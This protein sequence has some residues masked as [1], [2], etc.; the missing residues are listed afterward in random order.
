MSSDFVSK[1]GIR[2]LDADLQRLASNFSC[3][4]FHI[5]RF[6][7]SP[8]AL[9]SKYGKTYVWVTND[10]KGIIGF[11]NIEAG[12]VD[13][14]VDG[15]RSKMGGAIHINDFALDSRYQKIKIGEHSYISDLLLKDC[16]DRI[17]FIR[18]QFLGCTFITL[19]S[20]EA[21]R[22]LYLRNDFEQIEIDMDVTK[23]EEKETGCI[24]M[25]LPLD[26]E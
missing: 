9:D 15:E 11:Y 19:Q 6:I 21:G 4:N 3:G 16:I 20:N 24:A 25:Y 1:Y 22:K 26:I 8:L 7:K 18:D 10:N 2:R 17:R 13:Q 12:S 14:L 23:T 5:D